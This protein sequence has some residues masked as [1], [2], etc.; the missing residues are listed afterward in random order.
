MEDTIQKSD[1]IKDLILALLEF[2]KSVGKIAKQSENPFY[3]SKYAALPDILSAID[4]ILV[5]CGL[6]VVQV[7]VGENCLNTT[8]VHT[9]GQFISGTY[10]MSPKDNSPQGLGSAITYQRRYALAAILSL[11]I[12]EDDD[13]NAA[14]NAP[15]GGGNDKATQEVH[16]DGDPLTIHVLDVYS[17]KTKGGDPYQSLKT[18]LG[19]VM[20]WKDSKLIGEFV[21]GCTYDVKVVNGSVRALYNDIDQTPHGE[22][23]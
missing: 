23:E 14:S 3:K 6:A 5:E 2:H 11:N 8:L 18:E 1:S 20:V 7:P 4:P 12:D 22:E 9:S 10:K 19:K 15:Q 16:P 13:G 21:K 17:G